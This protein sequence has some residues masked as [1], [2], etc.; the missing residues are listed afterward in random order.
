MKNYFTFLFL[1]L[2]ATS[3]GQITISG[4]VINIKTN[5]AIAG[6]NVF[7]SNNQINGLTSTNPAVYTARQSKGIYFQDSKDSK[8]SC[9]RIKY[10]KQGFYAWGDN[11]TAQGQITYN[12]MHHTQ[13]PLY[14]YDGPSTNIGTF[15]NIGDAIRNS[16]PPRA[17]NCN[18]NGF[19][20]VRC[21]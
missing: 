21:Q 16:R 9:N 5:E 10:V 13:S 20:G 17:I 3:Y 2:H 1:L 12:K 6:A 4:N 15:G 14:T 8:I 18:P 11:T 7:I 19:G